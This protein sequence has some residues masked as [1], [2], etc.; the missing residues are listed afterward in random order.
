MSPDPIRFLSEVLSTLCFAPALIPLAHQRRHFALFVGL[1]QFL[2]SFLYDWSD[3]LDAKLFISVGAWH[4]ISDVLTL[5]YVLLLLVHLSSVDDPGVHSVLGYMAFF[6]SWIFKYR[7]AWDSV[8]WETALVFGFAM[9][10]AHSHWR[11]GN[12]MARFKWERLS[13]GSSAA[14]LGLG[15]FGLQQWYAM[16]DV[17][18]VFMGLAHAFAGYALYQLWYALPPPTS[19]KFEDQ[20]Y[21]ANG[22]TFV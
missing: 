17:H 5:T 19:K 1:T 3:Y 4:F 8:L 9:F 14:A 11:D 10:L 20:F 16:S 18:R 15:F 21:R 7:D 6:T 12:K 13:N 2:S 22:P